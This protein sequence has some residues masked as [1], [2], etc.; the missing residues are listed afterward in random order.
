MPII[1]AV[2]EHSLIA[3]EAVA[4]AACLGVIGFTMWLVFAPF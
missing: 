2:Y 3:L 1:R 4:T